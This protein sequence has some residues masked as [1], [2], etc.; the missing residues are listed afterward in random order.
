VLAALNG[1]WGLNLSR[2][3]LLPVAAAVGSDVGAFLAP[4]AAWCTGRGELVEPEA[5]G[6]E[7]HFVVVKPPVG[8]PTAEVYRRVNV[9]ERPRE[10][11]ALR[12][13]LRR[14]DADHLAHDLHNRLQSA[15][16]ALRPELVAVA[17]RLADCRPLGWQLSGSGSALFAVCRD[18]ADALRVAQEYLLRCGPSPVGTPADRVF[19][20]RC[21]RWP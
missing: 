15:A 12:A 21:A 18:R 9:P 17:R 1:L 8:C 19:P 6:G 20:V 11:S 10:G 4:P 3:E 2:R 5:V 14:G 16:F 7:F 13:A